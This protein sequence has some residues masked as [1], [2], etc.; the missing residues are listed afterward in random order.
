MITYYSL[1]KIRKN[2]IVHVLEDFK[3]PSDST[4][5]RI[6]KKIADP[7]NINTYIT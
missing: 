5:L 2:T 1:N 3:F 4:V 6:N 7:Y